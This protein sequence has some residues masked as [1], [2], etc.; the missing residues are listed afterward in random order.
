MVEASAV[1]SCS[2][3]LPFVR[4]HALWLDRIAWLPGFRGSETVVWKGPA[5][6]TSSSESIPMPL[7]HLLPVPELSGRREARIRALRGKYSFIPTSSE[8]Y[9][10]SKL[11]ERV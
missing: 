6:V 3:T 5:G 11:A 7:A 8:D 1:E 2:D 9:A 4:E 10:R